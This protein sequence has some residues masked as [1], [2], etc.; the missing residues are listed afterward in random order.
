MGNGH[1]VSA[2]ITSKKIAQK[3]SSTGLEYFNTVS[4]LKTSCLNTSV[5][6]L[7]L[8][9]IQFGGNPVS[10]AVSEA[11]LSVVEEENLQEKAKEL[12]SYLLGKLTALRECHSVIGDVRGLG[13]N[14]GVDIVKDKDS[15]ESNAHLANLIKSRCV[16]DV[17]VFF[18]FFTFF[19]YQA[20]LQAQDYPECY[21]CE[22]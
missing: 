3:F 19:I 10:M 11:V 22:W 8:C 17:T 4:M 16:T 5:L 6:F 9:I 18:V 14:I 7:F 20:V 1:P 21:W 12:G 13:L 2:V 15:R